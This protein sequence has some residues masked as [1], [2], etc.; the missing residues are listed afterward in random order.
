MRRCNRVP[1]GRTH[2]RI[3]II[4]LFIILLSLFSLLKK[5]VLPFPSSYMENRRIII[6][7]LAYLFGTFFL[8]PDLDVKSGPYNRWGVFKIIWLPY[9]FFGHR[10][11]LHH[12]VLGPV[13][14][15]LT[16]AIL[17]YFLLLLL[18]IDAGELPVWIW[19]S[20]LSGIFISIEIHCL[21]DM[22]WGKICRQWR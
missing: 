12:P 7:S 3:N 2:N 6:F 18:N 19:T 22:L 8:S 20:A 9:Q 11:I 21:S 5:P 14:L 13:I 15:T 1:S 4:A 16:P 17:L 10:G